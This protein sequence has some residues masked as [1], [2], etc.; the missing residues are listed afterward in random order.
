MSIINVLDPVCVCKVP[1]VIK[2]H[3]QS[4]HQSMLIN[5]INKS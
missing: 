5:L 2:T 3:S 4:A 1:A